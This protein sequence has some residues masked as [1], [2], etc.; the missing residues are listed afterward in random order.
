MKREQSETTDG[1]T[2]R[3]F[4]PSNTEPKGNIKTDIEQIMGLPKCRETYGNRDMVVPLS[5]ITRVSRTVGLTSK[6]RGSISGSFRVLTRRYSHGFDIK[7]PKKYTR[8][9]KFCGDYPDKPVDRNLYSILLDPDMFMIAYDKLKS[10]PGNMTPG[11]NP[12][13]LDGLNMD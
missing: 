7:M 10:R 9:I 2:R 1:V 6:A 12:E 4:E 11:L 13:T 5:P 3:Y 8:L